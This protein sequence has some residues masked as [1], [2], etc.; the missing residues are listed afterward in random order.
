[1]GRGEER[2]EVFGR[3]L[4]IDNK[5]S[6]S[7][8]D[9]SATVTALPGRVCPLTDIISNFAGDGEGQWRPGYLSVAARAAADVTS[10]QRDTRARNF[11]PHLCLDVLHPSSVL[12]FIFPFISS[13]HPHLD[14]NR[15]DRG[16]AVSPGANDC[17]GE[18]RWSADSLQA[19]AASSKR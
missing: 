6:I 14:C 19:W 11:F 17:I 2:R 13:R 8:R 12:F 3:L 5:E 18:T 7:P 10:V 15:N 16:I 9:C 4:L 1:M